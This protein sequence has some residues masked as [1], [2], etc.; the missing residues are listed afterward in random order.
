MLPPDDLL[1]LWKSR[2]KHYREFHAGMREIDDIYANNATIPLPDAGKDVKPSTP[3]L[4]A[5]GVD[6]TAARIAS[7]IPQII[8]SAGPTKSG[9]DK[10]TTE[11]RARTAQ[12]AITGWWQS[13]RM[14][15]KLKHRARHLVAYGISPVVTRYDEDCQRPKW[16]VRDPRTTYPTVA[17]YSENPVPE[18]VIF[19][20]KRP[21]AWL[22][23]HGY[24]EHLTAVTGKQPR[25]L[26]A[27]TSMQ[28]IEHVTPEGTC[29]YLTGISDPY[30]SERDGTT[31][32]TPPTYM[33]DPNSLRCVP[34]EMAT[35]P[36]EIMLATVPSRIALNGPAGQFDTMVST[37]YT[38]ARLAALEILAIEKGI[39]PDTYLIGRPGEQPD[40]IDGPHDG[41]TGKVNIVQ[42]G[43]ILTEQYTPGYMTNSAIDRMERSQRLTAGIPSEF[44]GESG[45]NIR[46]ARR[47]DAVLSGVIDHPIAEAQEVLAVALEAENRAAIAL[48]KMHDGSAPVS[49]Y[50]NV[51][52]ERQ[53]VTY[54]ANDVFDHD[55]HVVSYPV[56]GT[57][58]NTLLMTNGQRVGL[59]TMSK[60]TAMET[61]P[62]IANPEWEHDRIIAEGLEQAL[63]SGIQQQTASG[64]F[65]PVMVAKVMALVEGDRMELAE[66]LNKVAEDAAKEAQA[67]QQQQMAGPGAAPQTADQM[68]AGPSAAA[69]T[70]SP[71]P[72]PTPG[73]VSLGQLMSTVR[74]P[75]M[76]IQ[77]GRG[78]AQGAV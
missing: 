18:D 64:A 17:D 57:D 51:G 75:G 32:W 28:L 33:S 67:Q 62:A 19:A 74:K 5:Q 24:A 29:L 21:V 34:L 45:D 52:N 14:S 40:F 48:A 61:D 59:G 11:R 65:P 49:I 70:G 20:F 43:T 68:A 46:T 42:G 7:V 1:S 4:L 55:E 73:Q 31:I 58:I 26:G 3:N 76:T 41:R 78:M 60:R 8:F 27:D 72:G 38:W 9:V 30:R 44:G 63:V 10:R 50:V 71:I 2:E 15:L 25:D 69:L 39:F 54:I 37:F 35:L 6:Q 47:G 23:N 53:E 13:D 77:P 12:R 66:A 22:V 36:K 56:T 16:K